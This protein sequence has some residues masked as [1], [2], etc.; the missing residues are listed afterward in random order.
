MKK[1][2]NKNL[3]EIKGGFGFWS[4]AGIVTAVIFVVGVL[5]GIARPLKCN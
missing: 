4:F 3:K 1:I 2:D 5:D